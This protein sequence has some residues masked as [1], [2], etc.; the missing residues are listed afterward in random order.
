MKEQIQTDLIKAL[1][2]KDDL[3]LQTLRLLANAIHNDEIAKQTQLS[4]TEIFA[5]IKKEVKKRKEAAE[6]FKTGDRMEQS[7]KEIAEAG[8]LGAYLPEDMSETEIIKIVE[9]EIT[10]HPDEKT[11][12]IIGLVMKRVGSSADGALVAKLVNNKLQ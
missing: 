8:I 10:N 9:E 5:V 12:Q 11:G 3:K 7:E 6:G 4:D 2:E 1:K